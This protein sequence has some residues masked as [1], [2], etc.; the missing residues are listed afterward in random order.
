MAILKNKHH[1]SDPVWHVQLIM[2]LAIGL[3]VAL[4]NRF[5]VGSRYLIPCIEALLLLALSFTTPREPVF[6][7]TL[8]RVNVILLIIVTSAANI[9]S[10]STVAQQ[11]LEGKNA[12]TTGHNL[13]LAA[14]NIYLTNII[15]FGL[16]Y[17]ELDGGGP[18]LR[19][20]V[21]KHELDFWFPQQIASSS[22]AQPKWK[23]TFTDYLYTSSTNAMAFS[24]TDTVPI[25]RRAKILMLMQAAIAL[26]AVALVAA[27]AVNIL[28]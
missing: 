17:W 5:S 8:R 11:L 9:Y 18:G 6:R 13:I 25:S 3:Q 10:L 22:D 26:V 20:K 19:R 14:V 21:P 12:T 1:D 4:P 27:R 7:S 2:L 15:V 16:L 24:P 28:T 23:P